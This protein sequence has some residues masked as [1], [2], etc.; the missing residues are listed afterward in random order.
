MSGHI[1]KCFWI[2]RQCC[3]SCRISGY[4]AWNS[5]YLLGSGIRSPSIF[6][7]LVLYFW[8]FFVDHSKSIEFWNLHHL[9]WWIL[10]Y[11][12]QLSSSSKATDLERQIGFY[13]LFFPSLVNTRNWNGYLQADFAREFRIWVWAVESF[14]FMLCFLS[15][16]W[17][18]HE[19]VLAWIKQCCRA[20]SLDERIGMVSKCRITC[21]IWCHWKEKKLKA[22]GTHWH[23]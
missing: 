20:F 8:S 2:D 7:N 17:K 12:R 14:S 19:I 15:K 9:I 21:E 6:R 11:S 3:F 1:M 5:N 18:K 16:E 22:M 10:T 23:S 13:L 4:I